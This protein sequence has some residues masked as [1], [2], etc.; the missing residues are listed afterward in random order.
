MARAIADQI[1]NEPN[2]FDM[3][4]WGERLEDEPCGSSMCIAGWAC[5]L[6]PDIEIKWRDDSTGEFDTQELSNEVVIHGIKFNIRAAAANALGMS[7]EEAEDLFLA[8]NER[9]TPRVAVAVL[10]SMA[11]GVSVYDSMTLHG[12]HGD[13]YDR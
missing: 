7:E 13:R 6:K 11:D 1:E 8:S 5:H 2:R 12:Y 10:R 9:M 4:S 3:D